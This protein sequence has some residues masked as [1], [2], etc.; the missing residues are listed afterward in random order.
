MAHMI[1]ISNK[2]SMFDDVVLWFCCFVILL[3][4]LSWQTTKQPDNKKTKQQN[5]FSL[6]FSLFFSIDI[7][8]FPTAVG[9]EGIL[10]LAKVE[11]GEVTK[12]KHRYCEVK[13][14]LLQCNIYA[15]GG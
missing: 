15:I 6:F 10:L 2:I 5:Y 4:V 13:A 9:T 1:L 7:L 11:G 14:M 8:H 3:N 12:W